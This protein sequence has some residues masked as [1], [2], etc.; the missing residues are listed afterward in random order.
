MFEGVADEIGENLSNTVGICV[1]QNVHIGFRSRQLNRIGTTEFKDELDG[2][3]EFT[4]INHLLFDGHL[5]SFYSRQIQYLVD[6]SQH[7]AIITLDDF[8]IFHT[9]FGRVCLSHHA[10]KAFNGIERRTY[11]MAHVGKE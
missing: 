11:F 3:T 2:A 6:Q 9:V 5:A 1:Q 10:R 8:H 4:Q 7:T